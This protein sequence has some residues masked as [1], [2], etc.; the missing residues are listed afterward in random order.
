MNLVATLAD[1]DAARLAVLSDFDG[2]LSQ[3]VDEPDR[4]G[5]FEDVISEAT[6]AGFELVQ[7]DVVREWGDV[8]VDIGLIVMRRTGADRGPWWRRRREPAP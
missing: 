3:I 2:S 4:H 5:S 8:D 1:G 6:S 7:T